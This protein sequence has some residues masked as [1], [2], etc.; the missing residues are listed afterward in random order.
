MS[1]YSLAYR[2]WHCMN[3]HK[4]FLLF[5]LGFFLNDLL[6]L[7]FFAHFPLNEKMNIH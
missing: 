6:V 5:G 3:L 2:K 1:D 7:N 4:F